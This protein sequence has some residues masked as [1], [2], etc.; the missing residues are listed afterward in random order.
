M[1]QSVLTDSQAQF[2]REE[3][4]SLAQV[5]LALSKL[6]L[7]R[8]ALDSLQKAI[9]Q[10]DELFLIVIAGEFNA[11]KSALINSLLGQRV[12]AEGTTPTTS[13]VTL[14]K[15]GERPSEQVSLLKVHCPCLLR[16]S[17]REINCQRG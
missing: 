16:R 2:L 7:S 3:K 9:L 10:L 12:L 14:I 11:G 17:I 15:W 13:R 6:D 8:E 1:R 5:Q 4:E